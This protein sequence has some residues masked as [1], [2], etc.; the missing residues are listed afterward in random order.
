MALAQAQLP[1]PVRSALD[2][3]RDFRQR[4]QLTSALDSAQKALKLSKGSCEE[5]SREIV[6]LLVEM[7]RFHDAAAS[8]ASWASHSA[9]PTEKASAE[10][11]QAKALLL[12]D[13]EK[14]QDSLLRQADEVLKHAST[15]NP[16]DAKIPL[17]EGK[18]LAA[19]KKDTEAKA[20]FQNCL[21]TPGA[22]PLECRRAGAY[23]KDVSLAVKDEAPEFS[24]VAPDGKPIT[25][26]SLAGKVV[27]ID[28]W[29]TWCGPCARDRSYIESIAEE[30]GHDKFVLLGISTDKD[31]SAWQ[32]VVAEEKMLGVQ[33]RDRK[34]E[35][36]ELF[37]VNGIP[38][39]FVLDGD[40]IIRFRTTGAMKDIR[41]TVRGLVKE[42]AAAAPVVAT[43]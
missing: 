29:A 3:S 21:A 5:C 6:S 41:S 33:V 28:F 36:Q 26:D 23:V 31:E 25:L 22:S 32:K 27:L 1:P 37:H 16:T 20:A 18:V 12:E 2:E 15:D 13:H 9:T 42:N 24:L 11:L 34:R 7:E 43:N 35:M 38:A 17:L 8:A 10:Y 4:E 30:F 39:Y 40:G 14:H 19:M